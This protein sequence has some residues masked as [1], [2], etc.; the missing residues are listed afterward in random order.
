[1]RKTIC[2]SIFLY[3]TV[4]FCLSS[5]VQQ[6]QIAYFQKAMNQSDTLAISTAYTPRIQTGDILAVPIGSLNPIASSFFNPFST[7]PVTSDNSSATLPTNNTPGTGGATSPGSGS[8]SPS[9]VQSSA[10]GFL[11]DANGTIE[12]PIIGVIKVA[13]LTTIEAKDLIK[14]KLKQ[15]LK[16]P[17]VNVRFLNYKISVLGEVLH[18]SVY[19]IPNETITLP[20]A[21]GLAGDMTIFGRRDNVLI[22]RDV[23]G[24]KEFGRV[25]LNSR[26]LFSSPY[27]YLHAN[28]VIYVEPNKG[29]IAQTDKVYQLLPVILSALSLISI[30]LIYSKK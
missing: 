9:L 14:S 28:D 22:I 26:E 10:P 12:L 1:M 21:L 23:N 18:P 27:Y 30:I 8:V 17:T 13:G 20:E 5:C 2:Q 7:M 11:V 16:E 4:I 24:K 6:K 15:Y 25:N 19:V 29:R 3:T